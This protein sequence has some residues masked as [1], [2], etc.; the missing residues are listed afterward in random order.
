MPIKRGLASL[1]AFLQLALSFSLSGYAAAAEMVVRPVDA[2]AAIPTGPVSVLYRSH[3]NAVTA[4]AAGSLP[5]LSGPSSRSAAP[6]VRRDAPAAA[7]RP[8]SAMSVPAASV[9][10]APAPSPSRAAPVSLTLAAPEAGAPV[11]PPTLVA[12][13]DGGPADLDRTTARVQAS[14]AL[15][16]LGGKAP[17]ESSRAAADKVFAD[18]LGEKL[19]ASDGAAVPTR[20]AE[21]PA[22]GLRQ[23][24]TPLAKT[25]VLPS[26]QEPKVPAAQAQASVGP[27]WHKPAV[28]WTA[29]GLAALGV[30]AAAPF[31]VV[32]V[33]LVAAAGSVTLSLLGIPQIIK[34]FKAGREGTK[35]VVLAGPLMWFAAA[36][37]LSLVSIA[38]GSSFW[39][40]V[41]NLAGVAESATVVAQLDYY[42]KDPQA[43]KATFL[44]LAAVALPIA[45]LASQALM[46]LSAGVNAAFTVA[47]SIL[48]VLDAPQ[49]RQNYH[50]FKAEGRAPRG[51]SP[52][53]KGLLIGGSLMHLFAALMGG[54]LRWALNATIAITMGAT[55]LAQMYLPRAANAVLGPLVRLADRLRPAHRSRLG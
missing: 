36:S 16:G 32:H 46:P 38:N 2:S 41:A 1:L 34:N 15:P 55:V 40:N 49:I 50:I 18:L 44:T 5:Q 21:D 43:L 26:E 7:L 42:K 29:G 10:A 28:K 24:G 4:L 27:F 25:Q 47:M 20:S 8:S 45:L 30:A 51:I 35:D 22:T 54:D 37:L 53:F 52:A 19:I 6:E 17:A 9:L 12:A 23:S 13:K 14:L 39:W 11:V 33:G 31:L 3:L 48:W